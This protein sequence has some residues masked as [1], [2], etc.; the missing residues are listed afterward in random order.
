MLVLKWNCSHG[1]HT[2][3]YQGIHLKDE[4]SKRK[5]WRL[6]SIAALRRWSA[7]KQLLF[8]CEEKKS[9]SVRLGE[10]MRNFESEKNFGWTQESTLNAKKMICLSIFGE[11]GSYMRRK[12]TRNLIL[13]SVVHVV[14]WYAIGFLFFGISHNIVNGNSIW[15]PALM[16]YLHIVVSHLTPIHSTLLHSVHNPNLRR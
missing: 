16:L 4:K 10:R 13:M 9:K 8:I 12:K 5:S 3:V 6:W 11:I 2:E 7:Y 1:W 15:I 14:I